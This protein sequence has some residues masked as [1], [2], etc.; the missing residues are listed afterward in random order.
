MLNVLGHSEQK[1]CYTLTVSDV[2]NVTGVDIMLVTLVHNRYHVNH[3]CTLTYIMLV[4]IVHNRYHV[5]HT[6]TLTD[7]MLVTLVH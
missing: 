5:S 1:K 7:I 2:L 4:T 6:C 3:N